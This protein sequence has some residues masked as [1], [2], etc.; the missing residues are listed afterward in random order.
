VQC[1]NARDAAIAGAS[2]SHQLLSNAL[3]LTPQSDN[4]ALSSI[5]IAQSA[6]S[7]VHASVAALALSISLQRTPTDLD[8]FAMNKGIL[9]T[10]QAI[11]TA[12]QSTLAT[13]GN[14]NA[15]VNNTGVGLV[16]AQI[17]LIT[18]NGPQIVN[19]QL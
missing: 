13:Q 16:T 7:T 3:Q 15:L 19:Q 6:L 8:L 14:A 10:I 17:A 2:T 12:Q 4:L 5:Q 18:S 1:Q 11:N 9:A